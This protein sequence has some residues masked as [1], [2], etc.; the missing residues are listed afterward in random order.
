MHEAAAVDALWAELARTDPKMFA[1]LWRRA[2][3]RGLVRAEAVAQLLDS[4]LPV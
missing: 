4:P 1:E 3:R 2:T